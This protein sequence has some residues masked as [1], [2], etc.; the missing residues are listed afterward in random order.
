[1]LLE[2]KIYNHVYCEMRY[3][4]DGCLGDIL[5]E[6]YGLIPNLTDYVG[7]IIKRFYQ[8]Y[9]Q[10]QFQVKIDEKKM[11]MYYELIIN[12]NGDEIVNDAFFKEIVV[13][14]KLYD[15]NKNELLKSNGEYNS[16][17]KVINGKIEELRVNVET[18]GRVI[19]L[20]W[21]IS[22]SL[23]HELT[24]AYEDWSRK[25]KNIENLRNLS[26]KNN[27]DMQFANLKSNVK[28]VKIISSMLLFLN[29]Q[30][31]SAQISE[32]YHEL[33]NK[34]DEINDSVSLT[35]IIK[36]TKIYNLFDVNGFYINE[37][38]R[39]DDNEMREN[40][41]Y[42]FNKLMGNNKH[43]DNYNQLIYYIWKL[44]LKREKKFIENAY[45]IG[46]QV[47][48]EKDNGGIYRNI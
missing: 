40:I 36:K 2:D 30:E 10:K 11:T 3:N 39:I 34:S 18:N 26:K 27:N 20:E 21:Q 31:I 12:I 19:G 35:N 15:V 38:K 4:E 14:F 46:Y 17:N 6:S 23:S 44:Y 37:F 25:C 47:Y 41:L 8:M 16:N 29:E 43:F 28:L 48:K 1:M 32:L 7:F 33:K 22:K 5:N 9:N 42:Y 13:V 45:K 24:H